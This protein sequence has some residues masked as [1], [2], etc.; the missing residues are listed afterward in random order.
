MKKPLPV[1]IVEALGW[2]YV[3]LAVVVS[4]I[5]LVKWPMKP[6]SLQIALLSSALATLF[7]CMVLALRKGRREWFAVPYAIFGSMFGIGIVGLLMAALNSTSVCVFGLFFLS[8]VVL[9]VVLLDLPSSERWF[10]EKSG[11]VPKRKGYGCLVVCLACIFVL[12]LL[13]VVFRPRVRIPTARIE[14][15]RSPPAES[16]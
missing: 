12:V 5:S 8:L 11:C 3:A 16:L 14:H 2:V 10:A 1:K 6:S 9:P 13:E 15:P 4:L 7:A